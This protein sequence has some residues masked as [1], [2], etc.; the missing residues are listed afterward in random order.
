MSSG[1]YH[2]ALLCLK[3]NVNGFPKISKE[4][5]EKRVEENLKVEEGRGMKKHERGESQRTIRE[6]KFKSGGAIERGKS[7]A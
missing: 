6:M 7:I 4:K 5:K 3:H 1:K 2:V